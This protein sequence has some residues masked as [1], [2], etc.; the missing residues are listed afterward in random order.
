[1]HEPRRTQHPKTP[2]GAESLLIV[3]CVQRLLRLRG[4]R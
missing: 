3:R 1:V 2:C 4:R